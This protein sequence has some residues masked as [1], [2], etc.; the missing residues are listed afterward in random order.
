MESD[1]NQAQGPRRHTRV[2]FYSK[3]ALSQTSTMPDDDNDEGN[4]ACIRDAI[5]KFIKETGT[6]AQI[7]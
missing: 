7:T 3:S 5:T 2:L 6:K 4:D 1:C